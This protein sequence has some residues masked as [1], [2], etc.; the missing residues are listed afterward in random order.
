MAND[1][2]E[3]KGDDAGKQPIP[4]AKRKILQQQFEH[5]SRSSSK[6]D[7]DYAND[8]FTR[9]VIGDPG[10]RLYAQSFLGNLQKKYNNDKKGAKFSGVRGAGPKTSLKKASVQKN[11]LGVI[12]AGTKLLELNPWDVPALVEMANACQAL[13]HEETEIVWLR[14]ALEADIKDPEVN[15]LLGRALGKQAQFDQAIICWQRVEQGKPKDEEARRAIADLTVEKTIHKGGYEDAETST[16][17]MADKQAKAE[18]MGEGGPRSTPEQQLE[19]YIAKNPTEIS[20]YIEL[21]DLHRR[22]E[23]FEE[24][25]AILLRALDASGGDANLRE[26][27]E[28]VQLRRQRQQ[29]EV[30]MR[31]HQTEQTAES[32]ALVKQLETELNNKE[33]EVYRNRCERYPGHA[34]W[35]FELGERLKKAGKYKEAI[36]V[37]QQAQ[38]DP[39][40]KGAVL[41]SMGLCFQKIEQYKLAMSQYESAI[42]ELSERDLDHKKEALY[43]AGRMAA[44]KMK[45]YDK[46]EKYLTELAGLD[47]GYRDVSELLDKIRRLRDKA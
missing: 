5:A 23:R 22:N 33:M 45:D 43:L 41:L 13:E 6:G 11:W 18:R 8:M 12:E 3:N 7:W 29:V 19:K 15:R 46:A 2:K 37:Y 30:A 34:G 26:R 4:A 38:S 1:G 17:V 35:K 44:A 25:E 42:G 24:E 28:D 27:V 31:R 40:R 21:A 36:T 39:R 32:E 47:F 10:N 20:K 9:C 14:G 16:D